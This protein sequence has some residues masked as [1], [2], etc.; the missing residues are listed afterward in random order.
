MELRK[1]FM[2]VSFRSGDS[3]R[4]QLENRMAANVVRSLVLCILCGSVSAVSYSVCPMD[5]D[6]T[7]NEEMSFL[8]GTTVIDVDCKNRGFS[9]VPELEM[10]ENVTVHRLYLDDNRIGSIPDNA[11]KD[12]RIVGIEL[13]G[14]SLTR[15][16]EDAFKGLEYF[17]EYLSLQRTSLRQ[18][19][20]TFLRG[21]TMLRTLDLSEVT[22]PVM[23]DLSNGTFGTLRMLDTLVLSRCG[24]RSIHDKTFLGVE[25]TLYLKLDGNRLTSI[26]TDSFD[27]LME[28]RTLNLDDN[29]IK[30]IPKRS[31]P[32]LINLRKLLLRRNQFTDEKAID[33][34]AF[35]SLGH[36]LMELDLSSNQLPK[37]PSHAFE[38]LFNLAT[39]RISDNQLRHLENGAFEKLRHLMTL[40][41]SGNSVHIKDE[42]LRGMEMSLVNLLLSR[43]GMTSETMPAKLGRFRYLQHLD[44]SENPI[45]KLTNESFS[46]STVNKIN[47]SNCH[48][49]SIDEDTFSE[50][51]APINVDL[52]YNNLED[53]NFVSDLCL[54][55]KLELDE[56]PINCD[57]GFL[58]TVRAE[59]TAFTGKCASPPDVRGDRIASAS[60]SLDVLERCGNETEIATCSWMLS[61]SS[62]FSISFFVCALCFV[63]YFV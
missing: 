17:M 47:L 63:I 15:I 28:L 11:F 52:T 44:L 13:A 19:P 18:E 33:A 34:K 23:R 10:L 30:K 61:G 38:H 2:F 42:V 46:G 22:T 51:N 59:T 32:T 8:R 35:M 3:S 53:I 26:P 48:I 54:F 40:D 27:P 9:Q 43:T 39:F 20:Y 6:C 41:L 60:K 62:S 21:M 14:N 1:C 57:C 56:N 25:S 36:N 31:F 49:S 7:E 24:V 37:L 12:M 4:R 55:K 16:A 5:C 50:L 45:D 58:K 29:Q